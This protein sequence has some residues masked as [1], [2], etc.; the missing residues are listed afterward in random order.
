MSKKIVFS[1]DNTHC[2][3]SII[4]YFM[5]DTIKSVKF[6]LILTGPIPCSIFNEA[7]RYGSDVIKPK[8]GTPTNPCDNIEI[9]NNYRNSRIFVIFSVFILGTLALGTYYMYCYSYLLS[10]EELHFEVHF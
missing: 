4:V 3:L 7:I 8:L 9:F 1:T 6:I 10:T 5:L 2:A